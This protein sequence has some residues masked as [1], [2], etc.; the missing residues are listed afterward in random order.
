MAEYHEQP[1]L[2]T[3]LT[4][5]KYPKRHQWAK[6]WTSS[7]RHFGHIT[8][9]RGEGGHHYVKSFFEGN[10][11]NL[12]EA[13]ERIQSSI[14]V[15]IQNFRR[16]MALKRDRIYTG[17]NAKRWKCLDP[18]LNTQIVPQAM[19]ELRKQ[20]ALAADELRRSDCTGKFE[21]SMGIPCYHTIR[22]YIQLKVTITSEVFHPHWHFDRHVE[23]SLRLPAPSRPPPAQ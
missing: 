15:F 16:D 13:K 6:A 8:T 5:Q 1:L 14:A 22:S 9:S 11:H 7:V 18:Q 10:R 20:L 12:N 4:E 2:T 19:E 17:V 3:Y 23:P 21:A